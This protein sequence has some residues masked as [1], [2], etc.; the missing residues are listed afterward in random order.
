MSLPKREFA[1][2]SSLPIA[3]DELYGVMRLRG[4]N[5][6]GFPVNVL[7]E[8]DGTLRSQLVL[9]DGTTQRRAKSETTGE[10]DAV[11]HGKD[12]GGTIDPLR[13][14][15]NQQL[16]VEV[17]SDPVPTD[18]TILGAAAA[19]F[20]PGT[21]AAET[22]EFYFN[23]VNYGAV[24]AVVNVGVDLGG[25]TAF[26]R[27]YVESLTVPDNDQTGWFGPYQLAGDDDVVASCATATTLQIH[28]RAY[29]IE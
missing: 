25:G 26:D 24:A 4:F 22:Y 6:T 12:S 3:V 20:N 23:V 21:A 2:P 28:I 11:I 15:A 10:L 29:R 7:V 9:Y 5:T 27:H 8:N 14:N 1:R 19:V 18:P 13:T 16:Q 17:I